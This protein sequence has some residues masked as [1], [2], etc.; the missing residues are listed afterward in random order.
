LDFD[1]L[2]NGEPRDNTQTTLEYMI[3]SVFRVL[4][5]YKSK[6]SFRNFRQFLATAV[7]I[8]IA[9]PILHPFNAFL[10]DY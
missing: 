5:S 8:N 4:E 6:G 9:T 2:I 7:D 10:D 1:A 3:V